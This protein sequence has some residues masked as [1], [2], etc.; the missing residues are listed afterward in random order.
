MGGGGVHYLGMGY[1]ETSNP[2][3]R[4]EKMGEWGIEPL[5]KTSLMGRQELHEGNDAIASCSRRKKSVLFLS[6]GVDSVA[7]G[8]GR[9]GAEMHATP[10]FGNAFKKIAKS[11]PVALRTPMN[12]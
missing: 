8:G 9:P 12:Q 10:F 1:G 2:A 11:R 6:D 3:V 7:E 5:K 4:E